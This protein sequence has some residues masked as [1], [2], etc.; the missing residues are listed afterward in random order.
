M[1]S[2]PRCESLDCRSF[3]EIRLDRGGR[4]V[5]NHGHYGNQRFRQ[6]AVGASQ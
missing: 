6:D 4:Q 3:M 1:N 2:C 5:N